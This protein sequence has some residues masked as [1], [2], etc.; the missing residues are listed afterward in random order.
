MSVIHRTTLT[1]GKLDLLAGWL[2]KQSWYAGEG[3]PRPARA[4]GFRLDD[5]EGEVGVEFAAVNDLA[6]GRPIAYFVPMTYRGAPLEGAEHALLGTSQHGVLGRRWIYDA[7]HDPVAVRELLAFVLGRTEAQAQSVNDTPDPTVEGVFGA[8]GQSADVESFTAADA[9]GGTDLA[10]RT[11]AAPGSHREL[12]VTLR[13]V[14]RPLA[15]ED[16]AGEPLGHV[17]ATYLL[18]D[19]TGVRGRYAVVREAAAG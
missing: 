10:I 12:I 13:R 2:P 18:P 19:G 17:T 8:P 4:G 11:A 5:P 16:G 14:L 3:A 15:E 7:A 9:G 1:P 6:A